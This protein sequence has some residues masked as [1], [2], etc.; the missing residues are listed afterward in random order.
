[1]ARRGNGAGRGG[2]AKG[3]GWGGPAMGSGWGGPARG[4]GHNSGMAAPF[5]T[6]NSAAAG[7]HS[8]EQSDRREELLEQLYDLALRAQHDMTRVRA[9]TAALE[10]LE[11]PRKSG[12]PAELR[13]VRF[14]RIV[15]E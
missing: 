13:E 5:E 15:S 11:G 8:F 12:Y 3:K 9:S 7:S 2:P 14:V 4:I 10:I 6:G 1:M